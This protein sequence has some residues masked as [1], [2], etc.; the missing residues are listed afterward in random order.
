M[1]GSQFSAF[2]SGAIMRNHHRQRHG[3]SGIPSRSRSDASNWATA[4]LSI[5]SQDSRQAQEL[6]K[7]AVQEMASVLESIKPSGAFSIA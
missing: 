7:A 6:K 2:R 3:Q 5:A 4:L 1:T